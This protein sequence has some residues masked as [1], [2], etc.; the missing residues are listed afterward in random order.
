MFRFVRGDG[1]DILYASAIGYL[2]GLAL[3]LGFLAMVYW[4]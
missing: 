1:E 4:G 3:V 2:V